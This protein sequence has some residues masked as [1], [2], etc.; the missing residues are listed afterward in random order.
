MTVAT[1]DFT[2]GP[3]TL[4]DI[5]TLSYNG[6][7][8][9]PLFT[10]EVSGQM[11]KD[12]ATR[13]VKCTE[14][15]ITVDGYVTLPDRA[16]SVSPTMVKLR[17]L[18]EQ[19]GGALVYKGRGMD[20]TVNPAGAVAGA[21]KDVAWGPVPEV[22]EFQPLGGGLSAKVRWRCKTRV[23]EMPSLVAG[24][25]TVGKGAAAVPLMQFNYETTVDYGE[26]GFSSLSVKGVLE[27]ALTRATVATRTLT[28]TVDDVRGEVDRRILGGVDLTRFMVKRRAFNV[29]RD[30]RVMAWDY[31]IEEKPYMDLPPECTIAHGTYSVRPTKQGMG[32]CTW[33]CSLRA[34]YVVR[35]DRPRR[36]A[37]IAFLSLLRLRMAF[38]KVP[39]NVDLTIK[40]PAPTSLA[41]SRGTLAAITL[42]GGPLSPLLPQYAYWKAAEL[43]GYFNKDTTKAVSDSRK[44]WLIDFGFDEGLYLDSKQISFNATW[45]L[46]A[47]LTHIMLA[48]GM[49]SKVEGARRDLWSTSVQNVMGSQSWLANRLDPKLDVIVD[50]GGG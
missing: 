35:A 12:D 26:D 22:L 21:T 42:T 49:W 1:I 25:P 41:P 28:Q 34:T 38:S 3:A 18:L 46:V 20:L 16:A 37:W 47:P 44:A 19:Q 2:T 23:P 5:G 17:T 39:P 9:S 4:P 40:S 24:M 8:F 50:L 13:T 45:R 36:T 6:C 48:S 29:S 33:L 11:V 43:W 27:I 10:T 30:K 14:Y 15:S 32:L 7:T 31:S